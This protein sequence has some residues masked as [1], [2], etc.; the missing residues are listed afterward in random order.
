MKK[1]TI[2]IVLAALCLFFEANAQQPFT[3]PPLKVGDTIPDITIQNVLNF[4]SKSI[5]LSDYNDQ[6]LIIDFWATSCIPCVRN[7]PII[8]GLQKKYAGKVFFLPVNYS[9]KYDSPAKV[10][11]FF[12]ARKSVFDLPSVVM[13]S[14]LYNLFQPPSLS[15]YVWIR[16][17]VVLNITDEVEV[18]EGKIE[19]VLKKEEVAL[20]QM[21]RAENN[22]DK[23]LFDNGNG[24]MGPSKYIMRSMLFPYDPKII[25]GGWDSDS[26]GKAVRIFYYNINTY[27]LLLSANPSYA[28]LS[29]R[30]IKQTTHLDLLEDLKPNEESLKRKYLFC[31]EATFP[32][33]P[34]KTALTYVKQDLD[35]YLPFVVDSTTVVDTCWVVRLSKVQKLKI[36]D[37]KEIGTNIEENLGLPVYFNNRALSLL[38]GIIEDYNKIP[39]I[40]ETGSDPNVWLKLPGN[41]KDFAA[42]SISLK[43]QGLLLTKEIRPVEY[44]VI[45]DRADAL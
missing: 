9:T 22:R 6:L 31:Y 29:K 37:P 8:Y 21:S 44:M 34:F 18:T 23:P 45:K 13:D 30:V 38:V 20:N 24:G 19:Q 25:G 28:H 2:L 26:T 3:K 40:N 4:K 33:V 5:K 32:P 15:V 11:A 42:L 10:K 1:I 12:K 7:M 43:K 27:G 14:V 17:G 36:G 39:V 41:L 35:R 16:N